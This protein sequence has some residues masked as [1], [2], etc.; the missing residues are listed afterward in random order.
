MNDPHARDGG[1]GDPFLRR[2][3]ELPEGYGRGTFDGGRW[4][5]VVRRSPDGR[6]VTLWGEEL[7]G[8]DRVSANVYRLRSG[9]RLKPCEMPEARVRRFVRDYRPDT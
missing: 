5:L 4:S 6:R 7:G 9:C 2:V 1:A 8:P 3:L